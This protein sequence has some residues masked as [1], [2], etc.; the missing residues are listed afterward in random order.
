MG[1]R[2]GFD[3][4]RLAAHMAVRS[5]LAVKRWSRRGLFLAGG[6]IVGVA[7]VLMAWLADHAQA[8]FA[9]LLG[10]HPSVAFAATPLGFAAAVFVA[11][12]FFPNSQGSGIPQAIAALQID[13]QARRGPLVSLKVAFG[14]IVVMTFG[15]LCGASAGREGPTV[16]VG[17]AIMYAIGGYAP[18][19]RAGFL[20]AGAAAGVAAAFNTPLAGIVFGI[21]EMSRSFEAR[22]SGLI[23]GAVIAAGLT[24][25]ALVGD[26]AYFGATNAGLPF[27]RAWIAV[28]I[29]AVLGGF[30]GGVFIR[31]SAAIAAG[32]PGGLGRAIKR[33]PVLFAAACGLVVAVCG[34]V[35]GNASIYG[36]GYEYAR[37][38]VHGAAA[39]DPWF[40]PLKFLATIASA[41]SGIPGGVFSPS[42]SVGAGL[43]GALAP[44]FPDLP[45]GAFVLI[46][47]V[48]YLAGVVQAP[49]TS[50]VIV[51]EMTGDHA[52]VIPLMAAALIA[53]QVSKMLSRHGLYHT[54][55]EQFL[56]PRPKDAAPSAS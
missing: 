12:R 16:Q 44:A 46:G 53:D 24:A 40:A 4:G 23:V 51:S 36:T 43:A 2:T 55:A 34:L 9:R 31:I 10:A 50:F 38:L 17:A 29:C 15:L 11:R 35:S 37:G 42:L 19:R 28:V 54:L 56:V 32:L 25:I 20:L 18:Y 8:L 5:R 48:S 6:V 45:V 27:G 52:M 33:R 21:E 3:R 22:T 26:Y 30:A 49:I 39:P 47:M 13:D 14:K 7:A 41:V 1:R